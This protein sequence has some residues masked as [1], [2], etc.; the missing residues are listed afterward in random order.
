M[1]YMPSYIYLL[2]AKRSVRYYP[3]KIV[4]CD[5]KLHLEA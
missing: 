5:Y 2:I 3:G 1:Q 4:T